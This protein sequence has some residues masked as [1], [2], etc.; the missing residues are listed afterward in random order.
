MTEEI[1]STRSLFNTLAAK[2]NPSKLHKFF[3]RLVTRLE[4]QDRRMDLMQQENKELME[5][6]EDV[7]AKAV[8]PPF[9]GDMEAQRD[10]VA[11]GAAVPK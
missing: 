9:K 5:R 10:N 11:L 4:E 8:M 7:A 3:E 2:P 6:I 1:V